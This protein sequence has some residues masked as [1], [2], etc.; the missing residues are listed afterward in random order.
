[1]AC[2]WLSLPSRN[3]TAGCA[4]LLISFNDGRRS[5]LLSPHSPLV[6]HPPHD[7]LLRTVICARKSKA[8]N[9]ASSTAQ[10]LHGETRAL[11]ATSSRSER[12]AQSSQRKS[13]GESLLYEGTAD[14]EY[15]HGYSMGRVCDRL[16]EVFL[17]EKTKEDDWRKL[18][19]LSDEWAKIRPYFFKRCKYKESLETNG[20]KKQNLF[21]FSE[22]L[23]KIDAEMEKHNQLFEYV[24]DN[25]PEL[26]VIVA[27]RRREFGDPFFHHV[28]LLCEASSVRLE[29]RDDNARLA[30]KCLAAVEAHDRALEDDVAI[31]LAQKKLDNILD[32]PSLDVAVSKIDVLAEKKQLDSTSMLLLA[33]SWANAKDSNTMPEELKDL[34]HHLYMVARGHMQRMIPKEIR[35]LQHI[36]SFEEPTQR[37]KATTEAFSPGDEYSEKEETLHTKPERL[38][39]WIKLVLDGYHLNKQNTEMESARQLMNPKVIIRLLQLQAVV[40]DQFL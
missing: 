27:G 10:K 26:D 40:E 32:S 6:N 13:K 4:G 2:Q 23:Q 9:A 15:E 12:K 14:F 5:S 39:K 35:I 31:T 38:L 8:E 36:L 17:A 19:L 21:L 20:K 34:M 28:H 7:P 25:W 1:M 22:K 18:L 3:A 29:K 11:T 24:K 37:F 30:A 33:K 16:M